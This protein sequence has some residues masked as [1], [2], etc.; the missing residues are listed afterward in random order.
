MPSLR[1]DLRLAA[2]LIG[3]TLSKVD[4]SALSLALPSLAAHFHSDAAGVQWASSAWC[5]A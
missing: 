3:V 4:S 5:R 2:L 1:I